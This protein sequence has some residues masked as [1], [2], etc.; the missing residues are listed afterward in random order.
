MY[1][2][3]KWLK[4]IAL[5]Y[6]NKMPSKEEVLTDIIKTNKKHIKRLLI[7]YDIT[8]TEAVIL[9]LKINRSFVDNVIIMR[10]DDDGLRLL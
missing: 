3:L 9:W 7:M 1:K 8:Y 2:L 5:T 6:I 10:A 4:E